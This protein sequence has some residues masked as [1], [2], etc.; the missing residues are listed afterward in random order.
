M[1][2]EQIGKEMDHLEKSWFDAN[3]AAEDAQTA[4]NKAGISEKR[5]RDIV[6]M[7]AR[8]DQA[9]KRKHEIMRQIEEL[10]DNLIA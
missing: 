4:L 10:E 3:K 6:H 1:N 8:L 2:M 9:E 5:A 7:L